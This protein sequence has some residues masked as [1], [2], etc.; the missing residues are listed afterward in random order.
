VSPGALRRRRRTFPPLR[1]TSSTRLP[2]AG[3][4]ANH[5]IALMQNDFIQ[6]FE[7]HVKH[8]AT[9]LLLLPIL[10]LFSAPAHSQALKIGWVDSQKLIEGFPEAQKAQKELDARVKVWKDSLELMTRG[11]QADVETYQRQEGQMTESAKKE[12]QQELV[13]RQRVVQEYEQ[14]KSNEAAQLRAAMF[15]PIQE[16]I[17]KAIEEVAREEKLNYVFNKTQD[18]NVLLL[19]A[20]PKYDYTFKVLDRLNRTTN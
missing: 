14:Q 16:K 18:I 9:L 8:R 6:H 20:E 11:F 1:R 12:K 10:F 7:V 2:A 4:F 17:L 5:Y 3:F 13:R 19:Y 15:Q